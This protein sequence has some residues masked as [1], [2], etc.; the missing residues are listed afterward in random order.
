MPSPVEIMEYDRAWAGA[1]AD[2][3]SA[4]RGALGGIAVHIDHIGSTAVPGLA[5]KPVIDVQISVGSLEPV[6]DF[7][8][9]FGTTRLRLP[10]GQSGAD[11]TLLQGAARSRRTHVHV[12]QVGSF[13]QQ[14]PLPF[15]DYLHSDSVTAAEYAA[16][17]RALAST[18]LPAATPVTDHASSAS[19]PDPAAASP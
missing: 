13:S 14:F 10:G 15:R 19:A 5:A 2:V 6:D 1:F 11:E 3:G 12:R 7:R 8:G 16:V 18:S 4:I 17:K 9:S